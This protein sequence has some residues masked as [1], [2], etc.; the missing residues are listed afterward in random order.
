MIDQSRS[1]AIKRAQ[2][3]RLLMR[4]IRIFLT[5]FSLLIKPSHWCKTNR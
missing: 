5:M 3:S 1:F 4:P 2:E